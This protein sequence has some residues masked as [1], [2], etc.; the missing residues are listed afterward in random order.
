MNRLPAIQLIGA[1]QQALP[2]RLRQ[3]HVA[4]QVAV[5]KPRAQRDVGTAVADGRDQPRDVLAAKLAVGIHAD[6]DVGAGRAARPTRLTRTS[7]RCR[8]C[9]VPHHDGAMP[10]R[11][12]R[13]GIRRA[14]V[15][16]DGAHRVDAGQPRWYAVEHGANGFRLVQRREIDDHIHMTTPCQEMRMNDDEQGGSRHTGTS[17]DQPADDTAP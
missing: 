9:G 13:R 6:N 2:A 15:N 16:H 12:G 17:Q 14:V 3:R 4:N 5:G 10:L 8:D 1:G 7:G 11:N